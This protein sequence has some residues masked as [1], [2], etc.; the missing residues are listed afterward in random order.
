M[1]VFNKSLMRKPE[2]LSSEPGL[3]SKIIDNRLKTT[4]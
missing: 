2:V 1:L 3:V 4:N